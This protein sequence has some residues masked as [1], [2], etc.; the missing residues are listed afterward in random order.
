MYNKRIAA[1]PFVPAYT[2]KDCCRAAF[3]R[4]KWCSFVYYVPELELIFAIEDF[5]D[6]KLFCDNLWNLRN[7]HGE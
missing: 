3:R 4:Y 7:S 5:D 1:F 6:Y 2:L